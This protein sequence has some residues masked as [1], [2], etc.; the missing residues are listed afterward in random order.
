L[1]ARANVYSSSAHDDDF[2]PWDRTV[3]YLRDEFDLKGNRRI[4][5]M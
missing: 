5:G 2:V 4:F 1:N 3:T